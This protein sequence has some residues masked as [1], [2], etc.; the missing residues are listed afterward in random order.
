MLQKAGTPES[1]LK[2]KVDVGCSPSRLWSQH[3]ITET[4]F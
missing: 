4:R 3:I 1:D 2:P